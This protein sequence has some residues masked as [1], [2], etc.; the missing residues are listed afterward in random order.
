LSDVVN[1][2]KMPLRPLINETT[3]VWYPAAKLARHCRN[4]KAGEVLTTFEYLL[5]FSSIVVQK[6]LNHIRDSEI[7]LS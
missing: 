7:E 6:L 3:F 1:K 2:K 4:R 5:R